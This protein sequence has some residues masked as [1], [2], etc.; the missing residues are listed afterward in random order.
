MPTRLHMEQVQALCRHWPLVEYRPK[1][2][3][4]LRLR[5]FVCYPSHRGAPAVPGNETHEVDSLVALV[6]FAEWI[7]KI[8]Q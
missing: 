3:Q 2:L 6:V 8:H 5:I 1:P 7:E 4:Y